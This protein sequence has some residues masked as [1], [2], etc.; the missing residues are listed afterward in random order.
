MERS[1]LKKLT[2][3][4]SVI[5]LLIIVCEIFIFNYASIVSHFLCKE[6]ISLDLTNARMFQM[7]Q[8]DDGTY[9]SG[10]T[11]AYIRFDDINTE[12]HT[13]YMDAFSRSEELS[14]HFSYN[15]ET[16]TEALS[17]TG[18]INIIKSNELSK[19]T[20]CSFTGKIEILK[21]YFEEEPDDNIIVKDIVINKKI[22]FNFSFIRVFAIFT[23]VA[24]IVCLLTLSAFKE[25]ISK[26][27]NFR[28]STAGVIILCILAVFLLSCYASD[29]LPNDFTEPDENQINKELVDAFE[30]G[31]V[32]LLREPEK[33]LLELENPYDRS[34]RSK[35]G[36]DFAWDHCYYDGHYYSYYG[37]A[38]VLLLFLPYHLI[39]GMYF[40]SVWAIF[41]FSIIGVIFLALTYYEIVKKHF[42][43]LPLGIAVA[44]MLILEISSGIWFST[45]IANF[46]EIAQSSG[47]AFV[48]MGAYF[49]IRSNAVSDGKL[50]RMCAVF[51]SIFLSLA[52]LCRPTLA[53]YCIVALIFIAF[54]TKKALNTG[55]KKSMLLYLLC[56]LLPFI[57]IGAVQM[58][59]N[60]LRFDS[61]FDFGIQYSLTIN[62][63]TK[64]EFHLPLVL[65][66]F[67]NFL[68]AFPTT[69]TGFPFIHS[70]YDDLQL[71]GFYFSANEIAVGI[72]FRALPVFAYLLAGKAYV[73]S[74]KNKKNAL[75]ITAACVIAPIV[76]I[77]SIWESG[78][79]VRYCAD[80]SWQI[81]IGAL[82][83]AYVIYSKTSEPIKNAAY[84]L[85]ILSLILCFAVNFSI[86]FEYIF[87]ISSVSFKAQMLSFG[88]LF[89]ITEIF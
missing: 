30:A 77:F 42:P 41:I 32:H 47:F 66:G 6:E 59:Y 51:S 7:E 69:S 68:F 2:I 80:F 84:K 27:I 44:G 65:T 64:A 36:G 83:I 25:K 40:P 86:I 19:H 22:P 60:Y 78:Y 31:Q 28:Y 73:L 15:D 87:D 70:N 82:I 23:P 74:G 50:S 39:T 38:P 17:T 3:R 5:A 62:D 52:V 81:V 61:F 43:L 1:E 37:I 20:L 54:G 9:S 58:I 10:G 71:N 35:S 18:L 14:V 56:T 16:M 46:Y 72:L 57:V 26:G 45:P 88:R 67:Y 55:G 8:R 63:F 48:T 85:M 12:V 76:I 24:L 34:Q 21:F 75:L 29:G 33:E 13:I 79:G 49:L 4:I 89:E 11:E 53:V